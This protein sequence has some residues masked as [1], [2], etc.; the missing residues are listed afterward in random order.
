MTLHKVKMKADVERGQSVTY[1]TCLHFTATCF[2]FPNVG[3]TQNYKKEVIYTE[4][5][6]EISALQK[7]IVYKICVCISVGK[8]M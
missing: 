7:M 6:K 2:G 3:C 8:Q 5:L 1:R 4:V